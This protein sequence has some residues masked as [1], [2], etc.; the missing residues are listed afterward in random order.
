MCLQRL[1]SNSNNFLAKSVPFPNVKLKLSTYIHHKSLQINF[2]TYYLEMWKSDSQKS[3]CIWGSFASRGLFHDLIWIESLFRRFLRRRHHG[4]PRRHGPC[5]ALGDCARPGTG[6][7]CLVRI[8][9]CERMGYEGFKEKVYI[10][11]CP[12]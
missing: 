8:R 4:Q 10:C 6:S 5:F 7:V 1:F 3:N 11:R 12:P 2:D 9:V